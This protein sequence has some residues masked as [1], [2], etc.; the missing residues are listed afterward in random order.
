MV[1]YVLTYWAGGH[2]KTRVVCSTKSEVLACV[3]TALPTFDLKIE[4]V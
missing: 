3:R 2:G 4:V 1:K